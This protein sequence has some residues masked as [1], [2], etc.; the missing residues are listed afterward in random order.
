MRPIGA[1][2]PF[3]RGGR[4]R[5][6]LLDPGG[7]AD[8]RVMVD[9]ELVH[10]FPHAVALK[11]GWSG[12]LPDGSELEVALRRR[13]GSLFARIDV[14]RNGSAVPGS[15]FDPAR[16]VSSGA[17]VL[18]LLGL[19]PLFAIMTRTRPGPATIA[20]GVALFVLGGVARV[21]IRKRLAA[22]A[23]LALG[24]AIL[25]AQAAN[26]ALAG[27]WGMAV[28]FTW[29]STVVLRDARAAMD[30]RGPESPVTPS[31]APR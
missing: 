26:L 4:P 8:I 16:M 28:L 11:A 22:V 12:A 5:V 13:Y 9:G 14:R 19:G 17:L 20:A 24:G 10:T 7:M 25:L 23:A 3:E 29:L 2:M 18:W 6:Q 1:A 31:A 21:G 27:S 15:A 30:L